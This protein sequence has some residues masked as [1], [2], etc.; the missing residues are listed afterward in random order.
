MHEDGNQ[1]ARPITSLLAR[2]FG[3]PRGLPGRIGGRLMAIEHARIYSFVVDALDPRPDDRILEVGSGSGVAAALVAERA[4]FVAAVDP[5]PVMTAQARRRLRAAMAAGRAE[6]VQAPAEQLPYA[7][8]SFTGAFTIFSLHHWSD[9]G[10]GLSE[11]RRVLRPGG[12][13]LVCERVEGH[14]HGSSGPAAGEEMFAHLIARLGDLG[15]I[16]VTRSEHELGRRKLTL[17]SARVP[18]ESSRAREIR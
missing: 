13:L 3:V 18:P 9:R 12:R 7:D 11:V 1:L 5:S 6:A 8:E 4:G 17:V 10:Q 15:F 2:M 14:G 16:G